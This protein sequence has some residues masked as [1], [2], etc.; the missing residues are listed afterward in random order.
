MHA[1]TCPT[2]NGLSGFVNQQCPFCGTHVGIHLPSR[3]LVVADRDGI[4]I[5]GR[6]WVRCSNWDDT[7]CNW[8]APAE[9]EMES[10][11]MRGRCF[12][13]SLLRAIP[14]PTDTIA[15]DKLRPAT[16]D[17]RLLIYQLADLG[18]P[19]E[20]FWRSEG[21][22]AFDL[23]SSLTTGKPVMIGHAN[24]V[25]TID[26][27][28]TQDA[29]RERLRVNLG[30]A[31]RTMLGHYRHEVGHY[32]EHVLVET[33]DGANR[34]LDECRQLFGDERASYSDA[35]D[36]H[37]KFGAPEN[38]RDSY[39]SEY[40]TMHPWEDFAECFAHYL[41][42]TGTIDTARESGLMLDK[43]QVRFSMD[44]D[45]VPLQ[46]YAHQPIERL[47][48]DWKW[49]ATMFN[50]VNAAMG[51]RPL[52]PFEIPKPVVDKLGFVHRVIRESARRNTSPDPMLADAAVTF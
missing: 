46:S 28:E 33:G 24:G 45:I 50:R 30:E 35:L 4:D 7:G 31:Y 10:A 40:A 47:L 18:L 5:D 29:Y 21:G 42:I 1:L 37:Y 26:L 2:C 39:I 12:A 34:Y 17:L 19:V 36:R 15:M 14:D 49:L 48:Y 38:W 6:H 13:E 9:V 23:R 20:P 41:H 25:I 3:S 16:L 44:R 8:M 51:R 22:L 32:Y 11:G 27:A 52:Y 43:E